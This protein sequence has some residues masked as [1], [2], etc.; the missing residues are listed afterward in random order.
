MLRNSNSNVSTL[1]LLRLVA[2]SAGISFKAETN[3]SCHL[4]WEHTCL[5]GSQHTNLHWYKT[6]R[7]THVCLT[8]FR[9]LIGELEDLSRGH[10]F[11]SSL[12]AEA[13]VGR[14]GLAS[15]VDNTSTVWNSEKPSLLL[16]S[17]ALVEDPYFGSSSP[18]LA[19]PKLRQYW[20]SARRIMLVQQS[21]CSSF[22]LHNYAHCAKIASRSPH[23]ICQCRAHKPVYSNPGPILHLK[24]FD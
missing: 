11:Q 10:S 1:Q 24:S 18:S 15:D 12:Q 19:P 23:A 9:M 14:T 6:I 5:N 20:K 13:S 4:N 22:C 17:L 3:P 21:I 8:L 2:N 7:D 16:R